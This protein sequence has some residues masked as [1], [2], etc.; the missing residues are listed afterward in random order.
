MYNAKANF[1]GCNETI[2][3][4]TSRHRHPLGRGTGEHFML[5]I[6]VIIKFV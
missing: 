5:V 3:F 1:V 4:L 6:T 2:N